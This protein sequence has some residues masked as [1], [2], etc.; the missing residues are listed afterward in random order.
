MTEGVGVP[1]ITVGLDMESNSC[2]HHVPHFKISI[3]NS[4]VPSS[5]FAS[6]FDTVYGLLST[7]TSNSWCILR[8]KPPFAMEGRFTQVYF[9]AEQSLIEKAVYV[10]S[11]VSVCTCTAKK[12]RAF[13]SWEVRGRRG[14]RGAC[15][16]Q[17]ERQLSYH[18]QPIEDIGVSER[19][20]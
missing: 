18:G 1:F 7:T 14:A 2:V 16:E 5:E 19:P 20:S 9:G 13:E 15:I 3:D 4:F 8:R 17:G 6:L 12:L 10:Q 11:K